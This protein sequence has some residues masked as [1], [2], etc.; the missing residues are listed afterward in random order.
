MATD[1]YAILGVEKTANS[2]EIK[3]AYRTKLKEKH[4][5]FNNQ[6]AVTLG[7]ELNLLN[8]DLILEKLDDKGAQ[9]KDE[10]EQLL[11]N[12]EEEK[13]SKT[14]KVQEINT[15]YEILS[16]ADARA[17]YDRAPEANVW[18]DVDVHYQQP[19][20]WDL[21][22][23]AWEKTDNR[24]DS[25][26]QKFYD[27]AKKMQEDKTTNPLRWADIG[28]QADAMEDD[29]ASLMI[30]EARKGLGIPT[31][32][33][34]WD[35]VFV[36]ISDG[37]K[38]LKQ[39]EKPSYDER[40]AELK[41]LNNMGE[42]HSTDPQQWHEL[43]SFW[44]E[45]GKPAVAEQLTQ[46]KNKLEVP[47]YQAPSAAPQ[48]VVEVASPSNKTSEVGETSEVKASDTQLNTNPPQP[49][50]PPT[51][52]TPKAE[53]E[54]NEKRAREIATAQQEKINRTEHAAQWESRSAPVL[55]V[56]E[57]FQAEYETRLHELPK[58]Q[59]QLQEKA[60]LLQENGKNLGVA[61]YFCSVLQAVQEQVG[62]FQQQQA[63]TLG[64]LHQ[65]R[66]HHVSNINQLE[67][68]HQE[69][70]ESLSVLQAEKQ[71]FKRQSTAAHGFNTTVSSVCKQMSN[72][73]VASLQA[74]DIIKMVQDSNQ[75]HEAAI[76][77]IENT[78]LSGFNL[79]GCQV[80]LGLPPSFGSNAKMQ[81]Q[82]NQ[83]KERMVEA[84]QQHKT[85][86]DPQYY[87]KNFQE[88]G[89]IDQQKARAVTQQQE[90]VGRIKQ[91]KELARDNLLLVDK[92]IEQLNE[93]QPHI[94]LPAVPLGSQIITTRDMRAKLADV[95]EYFSPQQIALLE[96]VLD[97]TKTPD[98]SPMVNKDI[99][100]WD[101]A[102]L[103]TTV[104]R[105]IIQHEQL[106]KVVAAQ[107]HEIK[108]ALE[109]P[110]LSGN[111][112]K[113]LKQD[114][115]A[116]PAYKEGASG[117]EVKLGDIKERFT[118]ISQTAKPIMALNMVEIN[119]SLAGKLETPAIAKPSQFSPLPKTR[120]VS[121]AV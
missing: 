76:Q 95:A 113:E 105:D 52:E 75:G 21:F 40:L 104:R 120:A 68:Q 8:K 29:I 25:A 80:S 58:L 117:M 43:I 101:V 31:P 94:K 60:D 46:L 4:T 15:A 47:D 85:N 59:Q 32:A 56:V 49:V 42:N 22:K 17:R 90:V 86:I 57:D 55:Q 114:I 3:R 108:A 112:V 92:S 103:K 41:L 61:S 63:S 99:A 96:A 20:G 7:A 36:T 107:N 87:D 27:T 88:M 14:E 98:L 74:D 6:E 116:A 37:M 64:E 54:L 9:R 23:N 89:K 70:A 65:R 100:E 48:V 81:A 5:D 121:M 38:T 28:R 93:G 91:A 82:L 19:A 39:Q 62:E 53:I 102:Q 30:D 77:A 44:T 118:E 69:A 35:D 16:N 13:K 50:E 34:F 78:K 24:N 109:K 18:A 106:A 119:N 110:Q 67:Q 115:T 33:R 10:I 26:A 12:I 83:Q 97:S 79:L 11:E 1:H 51:I 2:D 73:G 71:D 84:I 72:A 111:T 45:H 66:E